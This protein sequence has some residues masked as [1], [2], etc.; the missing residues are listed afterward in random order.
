MTR[1]Q[2]KSPSGNNRSESIEN[3]TIEVPIV[4]KCVS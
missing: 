2:S 4:S 3:D 1:E